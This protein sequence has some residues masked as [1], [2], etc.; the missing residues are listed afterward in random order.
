MYSFLFTQ[1]CLLQASASV[2]VRNNTRPHGRRVF[3]G[4]TD[5]NRKRNQQ[6]SIWLHISQC[7]PTNEGPAE[8]TQYVHLANQRKHT[9]QRNQTGTTK[10]WL[11]K[12][13]SRQTSE[14][15]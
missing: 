11:Q 14:Y 15:R 6:Q 5:E 3:P 9:Q 7:L 4:G 13:P 12:Y 8:H 2:R 1:H 10:K